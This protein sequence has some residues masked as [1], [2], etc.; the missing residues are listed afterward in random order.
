MSGKN[1]VIELNGRMLSSNQIAGFLD[2]DISKTVGGKSWFFACIYISI[3]AIN[4]WCNII[5][6]GSGI[7]THA[8]S[9]F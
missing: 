1:L 8:Q 3:K 9:G 2:F 5:W 4:W 7:P 6:V